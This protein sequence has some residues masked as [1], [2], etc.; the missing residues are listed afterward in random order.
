MDKWKKE[1]NIIKILLISFIIL[2]CMW[3]ILLWNENR[4]IVLDLNDVIISSNTDEYTYQ[5]ESIKYKQEDL[6]AHNKI[7]VSGWI[8][9]PGQEIKIASIRMVLKNISTGQYYLIPTTIVSREDVTEKFDDGYNHSLSGFKIN[10]PHNNKIDTGI[11]DY[12]IYALCCFNDREQL[13]PLN[14]TIKTWENNDVE[15]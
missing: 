8:S 11:Y 3:G 15:S 14:T 4:I 6:A 13:V 7:M 12:E 5:I 10:I 9:C 1:K 2:L